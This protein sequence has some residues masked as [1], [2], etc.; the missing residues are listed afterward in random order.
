MSAAC[1]PRREVR[2][3]F[4]EKELETHAQRSEETLW[5]SIPSSSR[6]GVPSAQTT[7][8]RG[9]PFLIPPFISSLG[10]V[11]CWRARGR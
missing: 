5:S 1:T 10:S 11:A 4:T 6:L 8:P 7:A 2:M 3:T 9:L